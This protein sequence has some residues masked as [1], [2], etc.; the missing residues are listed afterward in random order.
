MIVFNDHFIY[1]LKRKFKENFMDKVSG[2]PL[3][4]K[5]KDMV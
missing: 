5:F 3:Y 2:Y 1:V 4:L